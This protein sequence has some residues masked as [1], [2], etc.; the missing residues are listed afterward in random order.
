MDEF[1]KMDMF[2]LVTTVV[3]FLAGILGLVVLVYVIKI[4]RSVDNVAK[5]VSEESN[6]MRGDIAVLRTKI[7]DEGMKWKHISEFIGNIASRNHARSKKSE[8]K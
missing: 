8:K 5:N 6:N 2:F 3:V 1:F 4:L 7:R